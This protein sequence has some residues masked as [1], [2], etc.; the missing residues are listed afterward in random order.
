MSALLVSF[1][2]P[3]LY[4]KYKKEVDHACGEAKKQFD[5]HYGKMKER[6]QGKVAQKK[7]K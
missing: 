3:P 1:L 6:V 4:K 5:L 2:W 7:E